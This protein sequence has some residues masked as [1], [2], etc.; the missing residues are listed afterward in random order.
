MR[1][2]GR[3]WHRLACAYSIS[4]GIRRSQGISYAPFGMARFAWHGAGLFVV[5]SGK[6]GRALNCPLLYCLSR[7]CVLVKFSCL[8]ATC[9]AIR[10]KAGMASPCLF[11]QGRATK[12]NH[13]ASQTETCQNILGHSGNHKPTRAAYL[14]TI[15]LRRGALRTPRVTSYRAP[16]SS[17][18]GCA[19]R[20]GAS[21]C[22]RVLSG[23]RAVA[24][25]KVPL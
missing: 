17:E 21:T 9:G 20:H 7:F 23:R 14:S 1:S 8:F 16:H 4:T 11:Q 12:N 13:L 10:N 15:L 2:S 6:F 24:G 5:I 19:C 22:F 3:L 18:S 25:P